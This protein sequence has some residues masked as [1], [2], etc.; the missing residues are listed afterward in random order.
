ML[1]SMLKGTLNQLM[2]NHDKT[3]NGFVLPNTKKLGAI[4]A[5]YSGEVV[6]LPIWGDSSISTLVNRIVYLP[7]KAGA[8]GGSKL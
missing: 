3:T 2:V 5:I 6:Q 8:V 1:V 4:R 7:H